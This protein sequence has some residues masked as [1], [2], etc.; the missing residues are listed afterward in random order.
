[1]KSHYSVP[2]RNLISILRRSSR[3]V[4]LFGTAANSEDH[5]V[6][7]SEKYTETA[8]DGRVQF[9]VKTEQSAIGQASQKRSYG[10]AVDQRSVFK[11]H[12][13]SAW[14]RALA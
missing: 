3:L 11:L 6:G 14:L 5:D 10:H 12:Q 1:M 7:K 8:N 4:R 2:N 9:S 13:F